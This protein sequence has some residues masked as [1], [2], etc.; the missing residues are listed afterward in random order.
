MAKA[1]RRRRPNL[2]A[3]ALTEEEIYEQATAA[4]GE[5]IAKLEATCAALHSRVELTRRAFFTIAQH[6]AADMVIHQGKQ[7]ADATN[8][9]DAEM[10]AL[11][12]QLAALVPQQPEGTSE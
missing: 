6:R 5:E 8:Y 11:D 10:H 9:I 2:K 4:V 12:G 1:V 7:W 3:R